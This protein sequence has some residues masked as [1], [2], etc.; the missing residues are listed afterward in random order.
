MVGM[1][2]T[3]WNLIGWTNMEHLIEVE[4]M[5]AITISCMINSLAF[6]DLQE[7]PLGFKPSKSLDPFDTSQKKT[8]VHSCTLWYIITYPGNEYRQMVKYQFY[9]LNR[10]RFHPN[11]QAITGL[12]FFGLLRIF[13]C[14]PE[15]VVTRSQFVSRWSASWANCGPAPST[16][17]D[18]HWDSEKKNTGTIMRS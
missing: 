15:K 11:H 5:F 18:S 16:S 13:L 1:I 2:G 14:V 8:G 6:R 3:K 17:W 10:Q 7:K 4:R 9:V 12:D